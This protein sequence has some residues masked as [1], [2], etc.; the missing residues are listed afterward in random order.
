MLAKSN[1]AA[2]MLPGADF[3][4]REKLLPPARRLIDS[5]ALVVVSSNFNPGT[6]PIGTM[7]VII[8]LACT[9]YDWTPKEAIA[10]A[11]I[12]AAVS[13]GIGGERGSLE[14]GKAADLLILQDRWFEMIPYR[15]GH[16]PVAM[17]IKDGQITQNH[18]DEDMEECT[19][20]YYLA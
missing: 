2:V 6:S 7:P 12:N 19:V 1:T 18:L 5:G 13:L 20:D 14:V 15:M 17:V 8:G 10:A 4:M 9:L 3:T 16:N 11:T